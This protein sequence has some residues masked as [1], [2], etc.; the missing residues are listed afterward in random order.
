MPRSRHWRG[1]AGRDEHWRI[2]SYRPAADGR[3]LP[4]A[5]VPMRRCRDTPAA[6]RGPACRGSGNPR[7]PDR[8][9]SCHWSPPDACASSSSSTQSRPHP[10]APRA[11]PTCSIASVASP[12]KAWMS[13]VS[14][15]LRRNAAGHEIELQLGVERACGR[16]V[17]ALDV[18]GKN[19][20][21]GLADPLPLSPRAGAPAPSSGHR[22]SARP[23]HRDAGPGIRC[24]PR[25][26]A[27]P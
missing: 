9:R 22:S 1:N 13:S 10:S 24:G 23:A 6:C 7:G 20:E 26:R 25:R 5:S 16:A 17:A 12:M 8:R 15:L 11:C 19:L 18:I 3:A 4:S 21:L 27:P 2:R 14:R